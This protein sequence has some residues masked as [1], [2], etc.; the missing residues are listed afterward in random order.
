M[1]KVEAHLIKKVQRLKPILL[2]YAAGAI[3]SFR[4]SVHCVNQTFPGWSGDAEQKLVEQAE[5]CST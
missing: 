3:E 4:F 5:E 2:S 1:S